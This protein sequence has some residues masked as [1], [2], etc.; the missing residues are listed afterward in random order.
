MKIC[1]HLI[2]ILRIYMIQPY[3][4]PIPAGVKE[5]SLQMSRDKARHGN[6]EH[7]GVYSKTIQMAHTRRLMVIS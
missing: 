5:V 2:T 6:S 1:L 7:M 4:Q 3:L